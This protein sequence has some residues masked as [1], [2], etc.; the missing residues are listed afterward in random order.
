MLFGY[1]LCVG[2]RHGA[3]DALLCENWETLGRIGAALTFER[4]YSPI[5]SVLR[6]KYWGS[7]TPSER[8]HL[9]QLLVFDQLVLKASSR[10]NQFLLGYL[11]TPSYTG[12]K[13]DSYA[14][15]QLAPA[16]KLQE[17][18]AW[19]TLQEPI[20]A[21][22][23][24][25]SALSVALVRAEWTLD[26]FIRKNAAPFLFE[27]MVRQMANGRH[28]EVLESLIMTWVAEHRVPHQVL[29][30]TRWLVREKISSDSAWQ[31]LRSFALQRGHVLDDISEF[32]NHWAEKIQSSELS[33]TW[34]RQQHII[35]ITVR[36]LLNQIGFQILDMIYLALLVRHHDNRLVA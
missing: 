21:A 7:Q 16:D 17:L 25:L 31:Q 28:H 35:E 33:L 11:P 20:Y 26:R 30:R 15:A 36:T 12:P 6:L 14:G 23:A 5:G 24:E 9:E 29:D 4:V 3:V 18:N 32:A 22:L 19:G 2:D 10:S 34:T 1:D 8:E 13:V 27:H